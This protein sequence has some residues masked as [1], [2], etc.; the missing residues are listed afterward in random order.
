[1][2]KVNGMF[3]AND[4]KATATKRTGDQLT[5][6]TEHLHRPTAISQLRSTY[7]D[8]VGLSKIYDQGEDAVFALKDITCSIRDSEFLSIVGPSGCGKSTLL[9]CIA[10]L[11]TISGGSL[12]TR[13]TPIVGP[14]PNLGIVFQRDT[15]ADWRNILD[16]V[17]L[18]SE[19]RGLDRSVCEARARELL[20]M[21]GLRD[22]MHRRP[23][24]LSG[25]MR[26][27]AAICRALVDDP[28]L[29]LMD[30]P[31]GALDAMTRDQLTVEFQRI[32]T[33]TKKTVLFITHSISEAVFLSDRVIMMSRNPGRIVEIIDIDLPRPRHIAI[34]ETPEF[35]RYVGRIRSLFTSLGI[36]E[37]K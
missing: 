4:A 30:E 31:F 25:G 37:D 32:W 22:F 9:R 14:L 36:L 5:L 2:A 1:M 27:R 11:E 12:T 16:N 13:G 8:V 10:G 20:T 21:F 35:V 34:Q 17:L 7:V 6:K 28:A 29:L 19:F 24:Q 23:W 3:L 18:V 33:E 26:Q 15:L